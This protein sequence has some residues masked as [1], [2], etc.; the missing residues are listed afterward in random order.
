[1]QSFAWSR[2]AAEAGQLPQMWRE[3]RPAF[4]CFSATTSSRACHLFCPA[5]QD[6]MTF[7]CR[8]PSRLLYQFGAVRP[9]T[10]ARLAHHVRIALPNTRPGLFLRSASN[11]AAPV[12]TGTTT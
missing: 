6:D 4:G 9:R 11:A 3:E 12:Q 8:Q 1:M 5:N 10:S 7:F 2:V